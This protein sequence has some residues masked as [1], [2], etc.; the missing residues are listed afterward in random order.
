M[1]PTTLSNFLNSNTLPTPKCG[2]I[3]CIYRALKH[4]EGLKKPRGKQG[5]RGVEGKDIMGD[6]D[7][8]QS[9]RLR[10]RVGRILT[11]VYCGASDFLSN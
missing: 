8:L 11:N 10:D 2:K 1:T 5:E 6:V 9:P 3:N 7:S 4:I